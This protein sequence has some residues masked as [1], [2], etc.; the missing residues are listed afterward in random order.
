MHQT[1]FRFID[2]R[3][4]SAAVGLAKTAIY[5]RIKRNE[6]PA[7]VALGARCV[8]W[9]S[10]E[11][12]EWMEAQSQNRTT[13]VD[14]ARRRKALEAGAKSVAAREAKRSAAK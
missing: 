3:E 10:D 6:F 1:N 11:I 12:L 8:R 13:D 2:I 14:S 5:G 9:R 7:P 4:T